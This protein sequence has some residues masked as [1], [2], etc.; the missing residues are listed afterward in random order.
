MVQDDLGELERRAAE[1]HAASLTALGKLALVGRAGGRSVED[2][3]R[4]LAAAAEAGDAEADAMIAVVIGIDAQ[5]TSDWD[6]A[7]EYLGRAAARGYPAARA[8]LALYCP[9]PELAAASKALSP[10]AP[11]WRQLKEAID[12]GTLLRVPP[13]RIVRDSPYVAVFDGFATRLECEWMIGRA[14]PHLKRA[15][16]FDQQARVLSDASSRTNSAMQFD[17]LK[18]DFVLVALQARIAAASGFAPRCLEETNVLHYAVGQEFVGHY[19]FFTPDK[20]E[21]QREL[22]ERGQRAATLLIYLNDE[23][24]GGETAFEKLDW[25]YRGRPGDA[26]LFGNVDPSGAPDLQTLHAGL[27]PV[28]GEKWLLSQWI[29]SHPPRRPD[30]PAPRASL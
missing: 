23:F 1:N 18:A 19:D 24:E 14:N 21:F 22:S 25:R 27:P 7:L 10:P 3:L 26:L 4:L 2:G 5:S 8:Q 15:K 12:I 20:P 6:R 11:I 29:R 28:F 13:A 9:D 16:I 17:I 30:F